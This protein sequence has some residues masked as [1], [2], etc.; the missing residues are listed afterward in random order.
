MI[1]FSLYFDRKSAVSLAQQACGQLRSLILSGQLRA[2]ERLP[3]TR[4]L[5]QDWAVSRN[6][7]IETFEQL[8]AEGYLSALVGSGTRVAPVNPLLASQPELF[9]PAPP[10]IHPDMIDFAAASGTPDLDTFP[11]AAWRSCQNRAWDG[12]SAPELGFGDSRGDIQLRS[13]LAPWLLRSKGLSC[14]LEQIFLTTGITAG[15]ALV[16]GFLRHRLDTAVLEEPGLASLRRTLLTQGYQLQ[17]APVD[18]TGLRPQDLAASTQGRL[19]VVSPSHQFPT[20]AL[21]S[22]ER[23]QAVLAQLAQEKG[24]LF[25][26]DYDGDLRLK[27]SPVPP[28]ATLDPQRVFY[29]GSFNK[30][31]FPSLRSGFLVVPVELVAPLMKFRESRADWPATATQ[32]TLAQFL[33]GGFYDRRLAQLRKLYQQRR[34]FLDRSLQDRWGTS[35]ALRGAGAGAHG[36]MIAPSP[37]PDRFSNGAANIRV[38]RLADYARDKPPWTNAILLGWGNLDLDKIKRGLD[39]LAEGIHP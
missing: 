7:V 38:A 37:L 34:D 24:W 23:R 36:W 39:R 18:E 15:L 31:L 14:H 9:P 35:A 25:E 17:T 30:T 5:A 3:S 32:R 28:L 26:D 8:V 4:Q 1:N 11:H 21:L 2:N 13:A 16:G 33:A 20:G 6:V 27:G 29:A 10:A 22:I 12:L 19:W